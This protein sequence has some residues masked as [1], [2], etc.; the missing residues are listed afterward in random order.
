MPKLLQI[1]SVVNKGST[2]RIVEQIGEFVMKNG[3][4]SY[5]AS[6]RDSGESFSK[7]IKIGNS[8]DNKLHVLESRIFDN[9]GLSS[10]KPTINLIKKI[11]EIK[12]DIIH[13]HNIHGYYL[14]YEILFDYFKTIKTPI[15]W[16]LHDCWAL[17]G[18]C[19][20][21]SDIKCNKWK[22]ECSN[23]PKTQ[24]Y[25]KSFFLDKSTRNFHKKKKLFNSLDNL[26]IVTVSDWLS[27]IVN[28]SYLSALQIETIFNGVD[29]NI[30]KEYSDAEN[31]KYKYKITEKVLLLG[32]STTWQR[33]K[34]FYD[35]ITLSELLPSKYQI[36]LIGLTEEKIKKLPYNIIGLPRTENTKELAHFYFS[37]DILLNLSYQE[38]FGLSTVEA[39]ACGTP[40]IVYNCTA[41]PELITPKTGSIVQPGNINELISSIENI[42][43]KGKKFYS[44]NCIELV[45]SKYNKNNKYNEFLQLYIQKL[46]KI[47]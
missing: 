16:T 5:I 46:S 43:S 35:F 40:S 13:L 36:V 4:E 17:T 42:S 18:H 29:L 31:I 24:N 23:C 22:S 14:N 32:V 28:N 7:T 45:E 3:W 21:F 41:S 12:P 38:T 30:F 25:P 6:G 19:S 47:N 11:E 33:G 39:N 37:A 27:S 2:G 10:R 34:G 8:F 26:T 9:H 44:K 20:H 15:I 1:N